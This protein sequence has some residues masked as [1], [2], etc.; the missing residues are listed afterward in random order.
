ME[1]S[2]LVQN[3]VLGLRNRRNYSS[4]SLWQALMDVKQGDS[5]YRAA[6]MH[7]IPRKTL[8]NWMARWNIKSS[9]PMPKQLKLCPTNQ[10]GA[11][12]IKLI[13]TND[14]SMTTI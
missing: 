2:A 3:S 1:L 6:K 14:E 7:G 11:K 12:R 10:K 5:I 4:S 8:R 9:Y 13:L